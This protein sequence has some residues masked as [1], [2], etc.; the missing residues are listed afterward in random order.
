VAHASSVGAVSQFSFDGIF[1]GGSDLICWKDIRQSR[2]I[3]KR[4][5]G[6]IVIYFLGRRPSPWWR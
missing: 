5:A 1:D 6:T 2:N 4:E 3:F